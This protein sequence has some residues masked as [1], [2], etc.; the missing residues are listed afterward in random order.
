MFRNYI[1]IALRNLKK[2]KGYTLINLIG[3]SMGIGVCLIIFIF[4]QFHL[5][6]DSFNKKAANIYR[7]T[8]S[9]QQNK[10]LMVIFVVP[11][12]WRVRLHKPC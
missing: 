9:E 3:L 5:S 7:V 10:D 6:F 11:E 8:T 4:L 2:D 1:K 12:V